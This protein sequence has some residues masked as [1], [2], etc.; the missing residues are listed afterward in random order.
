MN[1]FR[2]YAP[3]YFNTVHYFNATA[4]KYWRALKQQGTLIRN[5]FTGAFEKS[6]FFATEID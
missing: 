5:R 3:L 2:I 6:I 4:A 1:P